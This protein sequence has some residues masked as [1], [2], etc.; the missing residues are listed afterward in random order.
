M[1]ESVVATPQKGDW[2]KLPKGRRPWAT[3]AILLLASIFRA[4]SD[5]GLVVPRSVAG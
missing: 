4:F 3:A 5:E 2:K 1:N